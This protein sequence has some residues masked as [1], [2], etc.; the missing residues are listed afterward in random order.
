MFS[1]RLLHC[2]M[3]YSIFTVLR[4]PLAQSLTLLKTKLDSFKLLMSVKMCLLQLRRVDTKNKTMFLIGIKLFDI[5]TNYL[6]RNTS[7]KYCFRNDR[8][9]FV[10]KWRVWSWQQNLL[11]EKLRPG[12][13]WYCRLTFL[14]P[15]WK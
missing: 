12:S 15:M 4:T 9:F 1:I 10:Y 14:I 6:L 3:Q 8:F 7:S 2:P 5:I 13:K 11:K